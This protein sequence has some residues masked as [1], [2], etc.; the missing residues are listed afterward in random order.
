M[1]LTRVGFGQSEAQVTT[2]GLGGEGVL[3]SKGGGAQGKAKGR[4][5]YTASLL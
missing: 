5:S 3:R 1:A 4:R 2:V